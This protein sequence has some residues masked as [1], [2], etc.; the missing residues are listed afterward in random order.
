MEVAFIP[1]AEINCDLGVVNAARVSLHKQSTLLP[2]S[3]G[4]WY[5]RFSDR[6]LIAYL[7]QHNHWT[8]FAHS[9]MYFDIYWPKDAQLYFL[10]NANLAGFSFVHYLDRSVIKG[11]LYSWVQNAHCFGNRVEDYIHDNLAEQYPVS[12][13]ALLPD[14]K[15]PTFT[16][17]H[18]AICTAED[19]LALQ[20]VDVGPEFYKVICATLRVK[21][22]LF[23]ARQIRTSQVGF[24][25]SDVYVENEAFVF[26]EVSRRYVQEEPQFYSIDTWRTRD[27]SKGV[28]QGST[29]TVSAEL[30]AQLQGMQ[31]AQHLVAH[32]HYVELTERMQIAP[33]QARAVLTQDMYTEFYMTGTLHRW[34]QFCALRLQ[35]EVQDETRQCAMLILAAL[36]AQFPE[37]YTAY[38]LANV[39][40]AGC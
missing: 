16:S 36:G 31:A 13:A 29:G 22:P 25:C 26:N 32:Q 8:P 28:K 9:R 33:E 34:A 39:K 4:S 24:A 10:K 35:P 11:S 7:A 37:W 6:R 5:L 18:G 30:N 40:Q 1:A 23:V 15:T 20:A 14:A 21:V 17:G 12:F 38:G 2:R 27:V 19:F 3:D